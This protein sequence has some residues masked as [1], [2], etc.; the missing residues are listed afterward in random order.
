MMNNWFC[1]IFVQKWYKFDDD[2]VSRCCLKDAVQN[3][4]GGSSSDEFTFRQST[5]AYMLVYIRDALKND[6]L[7]KCT[8]ADIPAKLH[9]RLLDEKRLETMRKRERSEA[10]NYL[11][12]NIILEEEFRNHKGADLYDLSKTDATKQLK[13][14]KT[15]TITKVKH[16]LS[17]TFVR[18]HVDT[19]NR[20]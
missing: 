18:I 11:Q 3:N 4:F 9:E 20:F 13:V 2:V 8:K 17:E 6:I 7:E 14:R 16:L 12:M 19:D 15:D 5:N 1:F 10:P